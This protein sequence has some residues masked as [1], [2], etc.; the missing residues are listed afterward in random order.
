MATALLVG[1]PNSGKSLLFNRL[2]GLQQKVAN[3]PGVT[4][5]IKRGK[6]NDLTL[7]DFPGTYTLNALTKDEDVAITKFEQELSKDDVKAVICVLDATRLEKSLVFGLQVLRL[8]QEHGKK[9]LF[10]LNMMDDIENNNLT[11]DI[12]GLSKELAVPVVGVSAR[13]R[14]GLDELKEQ[15]AQVEK[16]STQVPKEFLETNALAKDLAEKY[17]PIADV[18][19]KKMNFLDRIFLSSLFGGILF[20]IIMLI[21]F[22]SIFT[23]AVPFMD[24]VEAVLIFCGESLG[25][26]LPDGVFKDFLQDALFGGLGAF[27]VFVPQIFV[28]TFIIGLMEDSGYLARA[29]IICHRPLK[30]FGLSGKSFIPYLSGHACAIPAIYASRMIDSPKKRLITILTVPLISC[31]ARLPIYSLLIV[32]F[33]PATSVFT[34]Y[35]TYQGLTF[36]ALFLLGYVSAFLISGLYSK[37]VYKTESDAPFIIELPSYR[38]PLLRP[39]IR[40]S[41]KSSW[42]FMSEAGPIIFV[43]TVIVWVLGYFPNGPQNLDT[44]WLG[45]MGHWIEPAVEP[46]G[47]DWRFGVAILTSFVAREVFVGTLGTFFGIEA[48][49]EN[50]VG[51]AEQ[52]QATGLSLSSGIALLVFY[53]IALQ[54]VSTLAVIRRETGSFK[55]PVLLFLFYNLLGYVLALLSYQ[56]L[57]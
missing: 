30:M 26:F 16:Q 8:C 11:L 17:G 43:V 9:V 38:R 51:L 31:S 6:W 39:L 20:V 50:V 19:I 47:L 18:L 24:G 53:V 44:S 2:T 27:L 1:K 14:K 32:A 10:A 25:A 48:A 5:E 3:F 36:F 13:T 41:L 12:E 49:D 29:A 46:L 28:L 7:V 22:Q 34:G 15:V 21:L 54:C 37:F 56:L 42:D 40:R 23:W 35:L 33:I 55:V 45:E 52:V 57:A 4:V